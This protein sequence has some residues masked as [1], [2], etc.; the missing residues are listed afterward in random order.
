MNGTPMQGLTFM[1]VCHGN[2]SSKQR[3]TRIIIPTTNY[4]DFTNF[5]H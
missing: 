4:T 3:I 2:S 1:Y 5:L